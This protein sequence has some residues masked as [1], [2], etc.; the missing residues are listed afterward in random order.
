MGGEKPVSGS[1]GPRESPGKRVDLTSDRPT[2]S[3]ESP[4]AQESSPKPSKTQIIRLHLR[5]LTEPRAT[6]HQH[7]C[8]L[9]ESRGS[10]PECGAEID[11]TAKHPAGQGPKE[12]PRAEAAVD[13]FVKAQTNTS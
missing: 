11:L 1:V 5:S 8:L 7:L 12:G 4:R 2:V 6:E 3:T 10:G 13:T 9:G